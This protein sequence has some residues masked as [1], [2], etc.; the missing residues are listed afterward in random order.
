[1]KKVERLKAKCLVPVPVWIRK[2]F[3]TGTGTK[4]KRTLQKINSYA[5]YRYWYRTCT[6]MKCK[7][8]NPVKNWHN[9]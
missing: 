7:E 2:R 3:D 5:Y 1:M 4:Q 9:V 6:V 8:K